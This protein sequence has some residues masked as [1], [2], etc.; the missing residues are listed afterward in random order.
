MHVLIDR[1]GRNTYLNALRDA[2]SAILLPNRTEG[3]FLPALETM[4]MEVLT[5]CPD[6]V[7]NRDFCIDGSTALM[8]EWNTEAIVEAA[9]R[10]LRLSEEERQ[11][12][13]QQAKETAQRHSLDNERTAFQG[14]LRGLRSGEIAPPSGLPAWMP[15]FV[16]SWWA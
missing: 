8:P 9:D 7:G 4:A 15:D 14:I 12:L 13:L 3:F 5:V 16:A 1:M 6:C 2:R 10:A 11:Q